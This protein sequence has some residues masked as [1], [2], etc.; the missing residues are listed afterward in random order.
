MSG[1]NILKRKTKGLHRSAGDGFPIHVGSRRSQ[2]GPIPSFVVGDEGS[3]FTIHLLIGQEDS[4]D[5]THL[6]DSEG[7]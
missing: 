3:D 2:R 4:F 5:S 6:V 1:Q 7:C